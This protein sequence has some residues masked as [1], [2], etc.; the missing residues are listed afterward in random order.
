[1]FEAPKGL[2]DL[3]FV[4]A[5][6][7][8]TALVSVPLARR[9]LA[10]MRSAKLS[11]QRKADLESADRALQREIGERKRA[12][13]EIL[14]L[15]VDLESRVRDRT[16]ELEWANQDLASTAAMVEYSNDAI[17]GLNLNHKIISWNR[18]AERLYGYRVGEV[19]GQPVTKL[20][21]AATSS[22]PP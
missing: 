3:T 9:A 19:L 15:G 2:L 10:L 20:A 4:T 17:V 11:E 7:A 21:P 1:M 5:A 18:A 6:S 14:K 13:D 12:E 22:N 16:S 8:A